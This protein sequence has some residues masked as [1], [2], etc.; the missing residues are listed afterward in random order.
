[1]LNNDHCFWYYQAFE[2][3]CYSDTALGNKS[4]GCTYEASMAHTM[5]DF[6]ETHVIV[7]DGADTGNTWIPSGPMDIYINSTLHV[8]PQVSSFQD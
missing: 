6:E 1:L 5:G 7:Q 8:D 4:Q 2:A 3:G